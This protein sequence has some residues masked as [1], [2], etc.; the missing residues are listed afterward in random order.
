MHGGV[1]GYSCVPVFLYCSSNNRASTVL[2]LFQAAVGCWGLPSRIRCDKGGE[3]M[4][5]I[6]QL[7]KEKYIPS[8]T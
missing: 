1:D 3:N 7:Q 8:I 6:L 5:A 4:V 2:E